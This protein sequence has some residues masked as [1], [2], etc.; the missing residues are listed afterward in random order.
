MKLQTKNFGMIEYN[1]DKKIIFDNG[2]PGFEALKEYIIIE[3]EDVESPFV[4]LQSV[5]DGGISF[6]LVNP[7]L[8]KEDYS[9]NI[10]EEYVEQLGGGSIESFS[11]FC[12]IT[13]LESFETATINLLAP[14]IIQ[15]DKRRA[16]Q[17]VLEK[18]N[19]TT[20]HSIVELL[21]ERGE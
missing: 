10:K 16:M 5:E 8:F 3:D 19:Y 18:T 1:E 17:V 21:Q 13:L 7:Y 2:I 12:I 9:A 20:R 6:V 11:I 14:I 15:E 4:Y